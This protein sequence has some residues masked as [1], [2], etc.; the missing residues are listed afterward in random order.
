MTP[1]VAWLVRNWKLKILAVVLAV[2][3]LLAVAFSENPLSIRQYSAPIRY[4]DP[5]TGLVLV[6]PP[7][8]VTITVSGLNSAV[9]TLNDSNTYVPLDLSKIKVG[10]SQ[11]VFAQPTVLVTGVTV[12]GG[13]VALSFG[14]QELKQD[15][16]PVEVRLI[17]DTPGYKIVP[18]QTY[19]SC[20]NAAEP[21]KVTLSAPASYF[22]DLVAYVEVGGTLTGLTTHVPNLPIKFSQSGTPIDFASLNTF[23]KPGVVPSLMPNVKVTAVTSVS[24]KPVALRPRLTGVGQQAC[25]FSITGVTINPGGGVALVTGPT[26]V[27][28]AVPDVIDLPPV[29]ITGASV[30]VVRTLPVPLGDPKLAADPARVNVTAALQKQFD[31]AAPTPPPAPPVSPTP[32]PS[33]SASRSP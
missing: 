6:K 28:S 14:V 21:C 26:T 20:D 10:A 22:K 23:P 32:S 33:P 24:T 9:R 18:E 8:R 4:S 1:P 31:C 25:G 2:I 13:S 3:L 29:D 16:L 7:A 5:P 11:T 12:Q 17:K 30:S 27:V 15:T 19:G